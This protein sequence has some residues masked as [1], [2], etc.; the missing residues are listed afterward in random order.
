VVVGFRPP[1]F[2]AQYDDASVIV[3]PTREALECIC[4]VLLRTM[5]LTRCCAVSV[6]QSVE[7]VPRCRASIT[8][9]SAGRRCLVR[10][11][12]PTVYAC[13]ES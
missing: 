2:V 5:T 12:S 9:L 1:R 11:R 10:V 4:D 3:T 8:P 6:L 13:D 7:A